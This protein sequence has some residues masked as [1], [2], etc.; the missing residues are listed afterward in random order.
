MSAIRRRAAAE[1]RRSPGSPINSPV[2]P[3][4]VLNNDIATDFSIGRADVANAYGQ[5][6]RFV[7]N[8]RFR[9]DDYLIDN[10]VN[11][12]GRQVVNFRLG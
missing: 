7:T 1:T 10:Q 2:L 8:Q 12:A 9:H 3:E 6:S 4:S 5:L 11:A